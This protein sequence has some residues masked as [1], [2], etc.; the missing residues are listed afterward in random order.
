M[1][2]FDTRVLKKKFLVASGRVIP[3]EVKIEAG[4]ITSCGGVPT[5]NALKR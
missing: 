1:E 3:L 4:D 5:E 2:F